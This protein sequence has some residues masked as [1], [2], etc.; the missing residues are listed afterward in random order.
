MNFISAFDELGKLY[1]SVD[2]DQ[3]QEDIDE[4]VV[5]ETEEA[6]IEEPIEEAEEEVVNK[7]IVLEC[8][9]CGALVIK[10]ESEVTI[11]EESDLANVGEECAYCEESEG[12]KAIGTF[13][14]YVVETVDDEAVEEAEAAE[15][16]I[17]EEGI[18]DR[19]KKSSKNAA[20]SANNDDV[21]R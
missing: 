7:P 10:D 14:P 19:K 17:I 2:I 9:K 18:F 12:F 15:D 3:L 8:I 5:E 6:T 20:G 11:D 4:E 13:E 21:K 1:E 16:E